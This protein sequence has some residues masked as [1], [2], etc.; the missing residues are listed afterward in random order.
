MNGN[1]QYSTKMIFATLELLKCRSLT[2]KHF[3]ICSLNLRE[4]TKWK[5]KW[6]QRMQ[7]HTAHSIESLYYRQICNN[8]RKS[9]NR[10]SYFIRQCNWMH[11]IWTVGLLMMLLVVVRLLCHTYNSAYMQCSRQTVCTTYRSKAFHSQYHLQFSFDF[12]AGALY[13]H[14][15]LI[16]INSGR[17]IPLRLPALSTSYSFNHASTL[18]FRFCCIYSFIIITKTLAY[19]THF[20]ICHHV[21]NNKQYVST[22]KSFFKEFQWII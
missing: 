8:H 2:I 15:S 12:S 3:M 14:F 16:H 22:Y 6:Q 18:F 21:Q 10:D 17:N 13:V 7:V 4:W 5:K 20:T 1:L 11:L 19:R 9:I